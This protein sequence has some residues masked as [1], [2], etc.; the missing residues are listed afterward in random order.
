MLPP[1][2]LSSSLREMEIEEKR[3]VTV[4]VAKE[5]KTYKIT[6][7]I[8]NAWDILDT[9]KKDVIFFSLVL[10]FGLDV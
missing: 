1:G 3:L 5:D 8:P 6:H 2:D 4:I 7:E 9:L 10:N